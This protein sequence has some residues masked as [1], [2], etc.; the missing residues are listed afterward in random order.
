VRIGVRKKT[1]MASFARW[2]NSDDA[3]AVRSY[4]TSVV[5]QAAV[6]TVATHN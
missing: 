4:V 6:S 2:I 5:A 3:E 1:G